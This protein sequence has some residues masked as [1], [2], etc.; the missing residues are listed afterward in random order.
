MGKKAFF[1][2]LAA[3]A[4]LGCTLQ[5]PN[6]KTYLSLDSPVEKP[7]A[8]VAMV[9]TFPGSGKTWTAEDIRKTYDTA[10]D[11]GVGIST[12]HYDWAD[13]QPEK[14]EYKW[15]SLD[16]SCNEILSRNMSVSLV[17]TIVDAN[18]TGATPKGVPFTYFDDSAL[19]AKFKDFVLAALERCQGRISYLWIGSEVD[20]YFGSRDWQLDSFARFY[21]YTYKAVK[22]KYPGV[23]VGTISTFHY[24]KTK[25]NMDVIG[26]LGPIGD[27]VGFTYYP[28]MMGASPSEVDAAFAE[29]SLIAK[30]AGKK[31][32]V[33]ES[34][35][36]SQ[37]YGSGEMQQA[38]YIHDALSSYRAHLDSMEYLGFLYLYDL[39]ME[40]S[41]A[42]ENDLG[43]ELYSRDYLRF[44]ETPGFAYNNGTAKA[45]WGEFLAGM[46]SLE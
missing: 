28:Q 29:M 3:L 25:G 15:D 42:M 11:A 19:R 37:G 32:A 31:F 38:E 18:R 17:I 26:E 8:P 1:L 14:N 41:I 43:V 6:D 39:S 16:I 46:R 44:L 40:D 21:N 2:I 22:A 13:L 30:K 12:L 36:S 35:W 27:L 24:A 7:S 5:N 4:L 34:A 23:A 33:T 10:R 20:E 45:A 9:I